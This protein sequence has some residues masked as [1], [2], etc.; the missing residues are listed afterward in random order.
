MARNSRLLLQIK[1]TLRDGREEMILSDGNW[2]AATGPIVMSEIYD[3]ETYDARLEKP[4]WTVA[5]FDAS[6]WS[7]VRTAGHR[8]DILIAPQGPP[9]RKVQELKPVKV[10]KTPAGETV[11]DMGQNMVGWVKLKAQGR[12]EQ[13]S[14]FRHAEVLDKLGNFYIENLRAA[15][16]TVKYTIKGGGTEIFEPHFTFQGFRYV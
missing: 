6:Q 2:K 1:V 10:L 13:T 4:G 5:G 12:R 14:H 11:V 7:G 9:V 3:G 15:K 16:Q 8:K